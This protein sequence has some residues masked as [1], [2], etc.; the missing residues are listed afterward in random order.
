MRTFTLIGAGGP[1][2]FTF[3]GGWDELKPD[4]LLPVARAQVVHGAADKSKTT[5]YAVLNTAVRKELLHQLAGVPNILLDAI[6]DPEDLLFEVDT[7]DYHTGFKPKPKSEWRLLP[8]LDWAFEPPIYFTSLLPT[9]EHN[10]T[11]WI[12]PD[13]N[14]DTMPLNQWLW[15]ANL[16]KEF[17]GMEGDARVD[18]FHR[19]LAC[20]YTPHGTPFSNLNIVPHAA[21]IS[22]WSE[23][24]KLAALLNYEAIAATLPKLYVRVYDPGGDAAQSPMGVFGLAYDVAK[25]GVFGTKEKVEQVRMHDV[26]SYME[27]TLFQDEEAERRAKRMKPLRER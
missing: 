4:M 23:E 24:V 15:A 22:A 6:T 20:I 16:N 11:T 19:F 18:Y 5:E 3:P 7:T 14:F 12:G 21:L 2:E 1:M 9:V 27:H 17:K 25:S 8:Q 26:L 13:D 10:G